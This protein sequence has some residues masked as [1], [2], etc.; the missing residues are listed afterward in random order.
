MEV[1]EAGEERAV[2]GYEFQLGNYLRAHRELNRSCIELNVQIAAGFILSYEVYLERTLEALHKVMYEHEAARKLADSNCSDHD[3]F[4]P[5][6]V[7]N[8]HMQAELR[9]GQ[10]DRSPLLLNQRFWSPRRRRPRKTRASSK[11]TSSNSI[12]SSPED[13]R[14]TFMRVKKT[15]SSQVELR[16]SLI[17]THTL[18]SSSE[19][20]EQN[21]DNEE[22]INQQNYVQLYQV[23]RT[24]SK[25]TLPLPQQ[26]SRTDRPLSP[27]RGV[28]ESQKRSPPIK[29]N[30][31]QYIFVFLAA[32]LF[33]L[34]ASFLFLRNQ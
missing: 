24:D 2:G 29:S 34:A 4:L 7:A 26:Q 28:K 15:E 9:E 5:D 27:G 3:S 18:I 33:C 6:E 25:I 30:A 23:I 10:L 14:L 11:V 17:R 8:E 19:L 22:E 20:F 32:L 31:K 16:P 12:D 1:G 13:K 21:I